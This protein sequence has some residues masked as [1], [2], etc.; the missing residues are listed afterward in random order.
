ME[1]GDDDEARNIARQVRLRFRTSPLT[2]ETL[3][4]F[5][6]NSDF[7]RGTLG[8][9]GGQISQEALQLANV[10]IAPDPTARLRA[11]HELL[12]ETPLTVRDGADEEEED[13][14]DEDGVGSVGQTWDKAATAKLLLGIVQS[15]VLPPY[16]ATDLR[17]DPGFSN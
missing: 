12:N 5:A 6:E 4:S 15:M 7:L 14:A 3:H 13:D 1:N 8:S 2:I 9:L 11:L 17:V 16:D 10:L